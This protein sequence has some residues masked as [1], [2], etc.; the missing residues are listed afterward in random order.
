MVDIFASDAH[1]GSMLARALTLLAAFAIVFVTTAA[2]GHATRMA[3]GHGD[4]SV[5][6]AMTMHAVAGGHDCCDTD[7]PEGAAQDG[8]CDVA[9]AGLPAVLTTPA[10]EAAPAFAPARHALP[11]EGSPVSHSPGLNER[12][13]QTRLL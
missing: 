11:A 3:D 10:P 2:A 12:P 13:P 1:L 7:Q 5:T 6:S 9:C 4:H 8:L